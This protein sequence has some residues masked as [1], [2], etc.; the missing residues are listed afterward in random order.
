MLKALEL[1][2]QNQ[3]KGKLFSQLTNESYVRRMN[4]TTYITA[5][6]HFL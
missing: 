6:T 5:I 3:V 1:G 4:I 2:T